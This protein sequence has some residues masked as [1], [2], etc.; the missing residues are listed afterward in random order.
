MLNCTF[1]P[2]IN[3]NFDHIEPYYK[4]DKIDESIKNLKKNKN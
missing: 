2:N 4:K 3:K 1:K